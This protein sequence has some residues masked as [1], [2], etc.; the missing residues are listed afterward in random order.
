MS[1]PKENV[2]LDEY[3]LQC[4]TTGSPLYDYHVYTFDK[5]FGFL[6]LHHFTVIIPCLLICE[7]RRCDHYILV[8]KGNNR[9]RSSHGFVNKPGI[10]LSL[11]II[12]LER[13]WYE[14]SKD[15]PLIPERDASSGP[16]NMG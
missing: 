2:T 14:V 5:M 9:L 8:G 4:A 13:R 6:L 10:R 12:L 11:L 3:L 16:G 1:G 15:D 7:M